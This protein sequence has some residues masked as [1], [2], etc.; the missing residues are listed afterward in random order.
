MPALVGVFGLLCA[1]VF[2][3]AG[4]A[5]GAGCARKKASTQKDR[6]LSADERRQI[7][8]VIAFVSERGPDKDIWLIRPT[9]EETQLTGGAGAE[10]DSHEHNFPATF[11][12]GGQELLSIATREIDGAHR[13]QMR[14]RALP[15][16][17]GTGDKPVSLHP[18]GERGRNPSFA[19][20]GSFF[21]AETAF[22]GGFSDLVLMRPGA[23]PERLTDSK[24]G[25]FEPSVSPDGQKLA[26]VSSQDGN[27]EIYVMELSDRKPRRL[28]NSEREDGRPAWSPDG[29]WLAFMSR[30]EPRRVRVFVIG[31][32]GGAA[33]PLSGSLDT[34]DERDASWS[35]DGGSLVFVGRQKSGVTRIYKSS[36]G[37][38]GR[39]STAE[40][41]D[42]QRR[43]DQPAWSPDSKYLAYVSAAMPGKSSA[44]AGAGEADIHIMRAD[45]TG[46]TRLTTAKG[47]DWLPRWSPAP[48][49]EAPARWPPVAKP[50]GASA[51]PVTE[52]QV[53]A[54][55]QQAQA[56]EPE[57][58][59]LLQKLSASVKGQL[60]GL[61]N[62]F[63]SASSL[64]RKIADRLASRRAEA[65]EKALTAAEVVINDALR[66]TVVIEDKPAGHYTKSVNAVLAGLE[67]GGHEVAQVKNYWP[68]G[69]N[70]SGVNAVLRAPS[71]LLWEVQFHTSESLRTQHK[72][73]PQYRELRARDTPLARKQT[74]FD[75]MAA[76]WRDIQIP[77]RV[78][79]A[80]SLHTRE[81]IIKR[82]RP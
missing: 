11:R 44:G 4:V 27:P 19:P 79:D 29:R 22:F 13:E 6:P 12:P 62:R 59:P 53:R 21:V 54:Y 32:D 56:V 26:F 47:A 9:G 14:I 73:H 75:E 80:Q 43:D 66:Y 72:Y 15:G 81:E 82:T 31:A 8:G 57:A 3:V 36:R 7:P 28:T 34:G 60:S 61:E 67:A 63:K 64:R 45:G 69:D 10:P 17:E 42:G 1:C 55:Q 5:L 78:L 33:S 52:A 35:P 70:Y 74:L 40:L 48:Q 65:P 76:P 68:R 58:T 71:S 30:R 41:T 24:S 49:D 2:G 16:A 38:D 77:A 37:A 23:A 18:P 20:D 46:K 39:F 25:C 50:N 51:D